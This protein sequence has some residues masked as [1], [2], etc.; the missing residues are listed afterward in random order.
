M[1]R[2]WACLENE[3]EG[4]LENEDEGCLENEDE[5]YRETHG[6][7][8]NVVRGNVVRGNDVRGVF[9]GYSVGL[10]FREYGAGIKRSYKNKEDT[11]NYLIN[12]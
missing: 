3:D 10:R 2:S 8:G 6:V 4:C 5:G 11:T 9:V 1:A 7:R 12:I